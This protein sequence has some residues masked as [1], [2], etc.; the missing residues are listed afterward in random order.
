MK[1]K[2]YPK[3]YVDYEKIPEG[4]SPL[5]SGLHDKD[6]NRIG[7]VPMI[8]FNSYEEYE[9]FLGSDVKKVT[10]QIFLNQLHGLNSTKKSFRKTDGRSEILF[11]G[12]GWL[13]SLRR[14]EKIKHGPLLIW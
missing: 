14:L 3:E 9:K 6:G 2:Y 12:K 5:A 11:P 7:P 13:Y 10:P 8:H 4:A 1:N